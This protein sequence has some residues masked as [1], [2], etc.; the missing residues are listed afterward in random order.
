MANTTIPNLPAATSLSGSELVEIVQAGTTT[1]F[2]N[3]NL[4]GT[5]GNLV[6]IA[7]VTAPP[8]GSGNFFSFLTN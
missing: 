7:S 8:G 1:T 4:N 3:F 2:N 5:A 6:T